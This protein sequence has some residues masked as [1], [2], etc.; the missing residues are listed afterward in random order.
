MSNAFGKKNIPADTPEKG[1]LLIRVMQGEAQ[2]I[3]IGRFDTPVANVIN[4]ICS[5]LK[6]THKIN[7]EMRIKYFLYKRSYHTDDGIEI[8]AETDPAGQPVLLSDYNVQITGKLNLGALVVSSK[9][10]TD[11]T[12]ESDSIETSSINVTEETENIKQNDDEEIQD[13]DEIV[14]L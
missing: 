5:E 4:I 9:K 1:A 10:E 13:D 2:K 6:L 8:L 11:L 7:E 14:T 12:E 3:S